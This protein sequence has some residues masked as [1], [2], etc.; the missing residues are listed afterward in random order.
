MFADQER[1]LM[2]RM[3]FEVGVQ[4]LA[5]VRL[6]HIQEPRQLV[7]DEGK[8]LGHTRKAEPSFANFTLRDHLLQDQKM[9]LFVVLLDSG[10]CY[11][12]ENTPGKVGPFLS[13]GN[14]NV[15]NLFPALI[16]HTSDEFQHFKFGKNAR[17]SVDG[18]EKCE[19]PA[20]SKRV[21]S[22]I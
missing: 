8:N 2:L 15:G 17:S 12:I 10:F 13:V 22:S 7:V 14:R 19:Q 6:N 18:I 16:R 5:P 4:S 11:A 9:P 21:L 20:S 3:I 1:V